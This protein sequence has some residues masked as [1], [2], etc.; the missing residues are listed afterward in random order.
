MPTTGANGHARHGRDGERTEAELVVVVNINRRTNLRW[1]PDNKI[2]GNRA[3]CNN[4][5]GFLSKSREY[6]GGQ[7]C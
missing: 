4:I 6:F 1:L 5:L 2:A 7:R 3:I